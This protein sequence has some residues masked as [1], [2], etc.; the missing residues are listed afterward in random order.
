MVFLL[1]IMNEQ[2]KNTDFGY[3]AEGL[4]Y[5]SESFK[6]IHKEFQSLIYWVNNHEYHTNKSVEFDDLRQLQE[7]AVRL[8]VKCMKFIFE[9]NQEILK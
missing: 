2:I 7:K 6:K 3:E 5:L 9:A 1:I 4:D 8:K